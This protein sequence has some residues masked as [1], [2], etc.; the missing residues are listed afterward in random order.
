MSQR[1]TSTQEAMGM[2]GVGQCRAWDHASPSG[3]VRLSSVTGHHA[4]L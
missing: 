3:M 2:P 1:E 4:R